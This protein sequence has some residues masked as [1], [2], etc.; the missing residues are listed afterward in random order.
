MER[1]KLETIAHNEY[2]TVRIDRENSLILIERKSLPFLAL[3]DFVATADNILSAVTAAGGR[4]FGLLY[5]TRKGPAPGGNAYMKAFTRMAEELVAR[6]R[7]VA[8]VVSD[9]ETLELVRPFAPTGVDF[10]TDPAAARTALAHMATEGP[11][12][13]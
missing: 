2:V 8:A 1:A 4:E 12:K 7:H 13:S 5:D 9:Q 3:Q 6:F 10:F 11:A